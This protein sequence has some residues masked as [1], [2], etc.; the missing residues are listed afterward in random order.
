M[1]TGLVEKTGEVVRVERGRDQGHLALRAG[2]WDRPLERGE[3]IAVSGVCLTLAG[4][5]GD[6][7]RFDVLEET[8]R[9]TN[10][11]GKTPNSR[12]N[13]E[14]ALRYGDPL[15][16]HIVNGHVDGTGRVVAVTKLAP[17]VDWELRIACSAELMQYMVAKGSV[18]LD[19]VSLTLVQVRPDWFSVHIIP[20][21]WQVTSLSDLKSGDEVNLEPDVLCKYAKRMAGGG[22]S[23]PPLSWESLR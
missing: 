22:D 13:L 6:E 4:V 19:G 5:K 9:R 7:L 15:G 3:S 12:L 20:H 1:F 14:R 21:T 8:F 23:G 11:G 16:G 2:R 18:A 17:G 10:L